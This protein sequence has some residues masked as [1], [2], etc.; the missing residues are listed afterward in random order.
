MNDGCAGILTEWQFAFG[1]HFGIA[2]E[3]Q[4]HIF[5]VVA[6]FGVAQNF[7]HLFVVR[8]A[9][10]ER[11]IAKSGIRHGRQALFCNFQNR[12]TLEFAHRH[13]VACQQVVFGFVLAE[14]EHRLVMKF[15][16]HNNIL[17]L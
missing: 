5:V 11:H 6:G 7:G 17:I 16:C 8:T 14:R 10:Q 4:R 12:F 15:C 9:Q 2:Q 1:G 13:I 3:C